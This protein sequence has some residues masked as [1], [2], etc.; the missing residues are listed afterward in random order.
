MSHLSDQQLADY[1]K[2]LSPEQAAAIHKLRDLILEYSPSL[3]ESIDTGK[4][5][6]GML[7]YNTPE[8]TFVYA[9]GPRKNGYTAFHMMPY[10]SSSELQQK[11]GQELK[12]ILSGKSCIKFK[13]YDEVPEAAIRDILK[14]APAIMVEVQT[15]LAKRKAK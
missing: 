4:W 9:V 12:K 7:I 6:G 14:N 2:A 10:Y 3:N 15:F 13:S 5:F 11:H 8:G 1:T